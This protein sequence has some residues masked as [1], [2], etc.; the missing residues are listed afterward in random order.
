MNCIF[1][2]T[3]L[4][5]ALVGSAALALAACGGSSTPPPPPAPVTQTISAAAGGTINGP[6]GVVLTIAPDALAADTAIT[7]AIDDTGAPPLPAALTPLAVPMISLTPHGTTFSVP[8]TLSVPVP[9][10]QEL[11]VV[12][13]NERRDGWEALVPVRIR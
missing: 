13:T 8:V 9:A 7:I 2:T 11:V 5:R 12:K 6:G 3:G 1:W 4:A 10:G